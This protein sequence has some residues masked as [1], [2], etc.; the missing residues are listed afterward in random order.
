MSGVICQTQ[1]PTCSHSIKYNKLQ[2]TEGIY[3]LLLSC[4]LTSHTSSAIVQQHCQILQI[5]VQL[6]LWTASDDMQHSLSFAT[7]TVISSCKATLSAA[8]R[9]V[10]LVSP[11]VTSDVMA[12]RVLVTRSLSSDHH[13]ISTVARMSLPA[14]THNLYFSLLLFFFFYFRINSKQNLPITSGV[15]VDQKMKRK[16]QQVSSKYQR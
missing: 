7:S 8:R 2:C 5:I 3:W 10:D 6:A 16:P 4:A 12:D 15:K 13:K 11:L 9:A 1:F 14:L